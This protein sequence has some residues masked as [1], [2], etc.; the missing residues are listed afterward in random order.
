MLLHGWS[1]GGHP[2]RK[3]LRVTVCD[4]R[5]VPDV[6]EADTAV[7]AKEEQDGQVDAFEQQPGREAVETRGYG[8]VHTVSVDE[9]MEQPGGDVTDDQQAERTA[10]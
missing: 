5:R 7:K 10:T 8:E 3:L 6:C 1:D 9:R 2:I 4:V